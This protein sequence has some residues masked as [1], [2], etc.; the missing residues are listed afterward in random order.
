M[1]VDLKTLVEAVE[2]DVK[3]NHKGAI[4]IWGLEKAVEL[5]VGQRVV[6]MTIFGSSRRVGKGAAIIEKEII[7]AELKK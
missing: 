4:G 1:M 3:K 5:F 2:R 7:Q 6:E